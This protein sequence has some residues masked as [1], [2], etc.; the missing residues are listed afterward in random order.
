MFADQRV[1]PSSS[2]FAKG[3]RP[4]LGSAMEDGS[5]PT[6]SPLRH[7]QLAVLRGNRVLRNP[8]GQVGETLA[9][10]EIAQGF[11]KMTVELE[12]GEDWQ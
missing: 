10:A 7:F 12:I 2:P 3:V 4:N 8:G 1:Y 9:V 6:D 11:A 5:R